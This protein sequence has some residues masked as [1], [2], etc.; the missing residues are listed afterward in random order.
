MLQIQKMSKVGGE[1]IVKN[2][3]NI[4]SETISHE[5]AQAYTWTGQN[6]KLPLKKTRISDAIID[7]IYNI[8]CY[9]MFFV[10]NNI[11]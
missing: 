2:V 11:H 7:N 6:K 1:T 8:I 4:M 5:V 10:R 9:L 3:R